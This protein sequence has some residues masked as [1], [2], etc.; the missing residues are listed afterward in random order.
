MRS[1]PPRG[2]GWVRAQTPVTCKE[3]SLC[4]QARGDDRQDFMI[5]CRSPTYPLPRGGTDLM[6]SDSCT[7]GE[8]PNSISTTTRLAVRKERHIL[9]GN[10]RRSARMRAEVAVN[11]LNAFKQGFLI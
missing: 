10:S 9:S 6:G 5:E 2:S 7:K 8:H 3:V 1:V 4:A 11:L